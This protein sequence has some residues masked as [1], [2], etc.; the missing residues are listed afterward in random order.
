MFQIW[1]F[2]NPE[3]S[4]K[5]ACLHSHSN[6]SI[7]IRLTFYFG[8]KL[9]LAIFPDNSFQITPYDPPPQWHHEVILIFM[10]SGVTL[11][12]WYNQLDL[13]VH[14]TPILE[15]LLKRNS[16]QMLSN[17]SKYLWRSLQALGNVIVLYDYL[18]GCS[19]TIS[20]TWILTGLKLKVNQIL[21]SKT[22]F[23]RV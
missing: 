10:T 13:F 1:Y 22:S 2:G 4:G 21:H 7:P 14:A 16:A 23:A 3:Y 20:D 6:S 8:C 5:V 9:F 18:W 15:N 17:V 12:V 11:E 19:I